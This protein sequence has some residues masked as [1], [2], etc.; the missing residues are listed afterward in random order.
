[1][2]MTRSELIEWRQAL[3]FSMT[4]EAYRAE[5]FKLRP[6]DKAYAIALRGVGEIFPVSQYILECVTVLDAMDNLKKYL[7]ED[8]VVI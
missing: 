1:M 8:G 5:V 7:N 6:D 4:W 2:S 3:P